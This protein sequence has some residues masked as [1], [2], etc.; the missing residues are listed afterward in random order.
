MNRIKI[1]V[2]RISAPGGEELLELERLD[3]AAMGGAGAGRYTLRAVADCGWL[4]VA[5]APDGIAACA[6]YLPRAGDPASVH[7][8]GLFTVER[9]RG[10]GAGGTLLRG[11]LAALAACGVRRV[12]LT[13]APGNAAAISLYRKAGFRETGR[14][15]DHYGP[16]EARLIQTIALD[17]AG[18]PR[19]EA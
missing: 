5:R 15:A 10:L 13:V 8:F 12:D 4:F 18:A 2:E 7:L 14:C 16:G 19:E 6:Q 3:A 1:N 17:A 11:S 9:Y